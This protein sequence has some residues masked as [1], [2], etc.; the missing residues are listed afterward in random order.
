M[1]LVDLLEPVLINH[2]AVLLRVRHSV[3]H[4]A[5]SGLRQSPTAPRKSF[6]SACYSFHR[7]FKPFEWL[8]VPL[9]PVPHLPR[10]P[11][12]EA[13]DPLLRGLINAAARSWLSLLGLRT[14]RRG[15]CAEA[16]KRVEGAVKEESITD[17]GGWPRPVDVRIAVEPLVLIVSTKKRSRSK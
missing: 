9:Q 6:A 11:C 13:F 14:A 8:R 4:E 1:G 17:D 3:I 7:T 5:S 2:R 12:T 10:A 16:M 15:H